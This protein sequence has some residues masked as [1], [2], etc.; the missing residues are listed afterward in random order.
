MRGRVIGWPDE[1][2]ICV[3]YAGGGVVVR[4]DDPSNTYE[5]ESSPTITGLVVIPEREL[6]IFAD[7][8]NRV[9]YGRD[10]L[11]WRSRRLAVDDLQIDGPDGDDLHVRGFFG[12]GRLWPF[13]VDLATGEASGQPFQRSQLVAG[14]G[15][16]SGRD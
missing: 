16:P 14:P 11:V 5:I 2:S 8:T 6:V 13:T 12:S 1:W 7:W 9:A 10:G 4:T 15:A 3:V